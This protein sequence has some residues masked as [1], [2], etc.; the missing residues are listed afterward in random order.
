MDNYILLVFEGEK[1]EKNIF[2]SLQKYF[3]NERKN[4]VLISVY[5]SDIYS[6]YREMNEDQ[7]LDL[8]PIIKDKKKNKEHLRNISRNS[9]SEIFLFFDYDGHATLASDDNLMELLNHFDEETG[10]G[11]LYLSYPMVEAIKHL[12]HDVPFENVV[13]DAKRNIK[14]KE[15]VYTEGDTCYANLAALG[16]DHWNTIIN[17]H[18]KKLNHLM[19]NCFEL[20]V[21]LI[22]QITAF[23]MQREK[24]IEPDDMIAVLSGFPV[25]LADYYGYKA[26]FARSAKNGL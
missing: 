11:K 24:H 18:C 5:C 8:F 3:L 13:V 14:Y 21:S 9:V 10:N 26:F 19:T 6:L 20:P 25:F 22:T 16:Q 7:Y 17:E 15:I 23:S 12:H 2:R 1:T 4:T